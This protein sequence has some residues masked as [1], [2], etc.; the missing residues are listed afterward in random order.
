MGAWTQFGGISIE[1]G[2]TLI[3]IAGSFT[4]IAGVSIEG[5]DDWNRI[6]GVSTEMLV[7]VQRIGGSE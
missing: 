6:A 3:A 4:E 2:S 7:L 5:P 1:S